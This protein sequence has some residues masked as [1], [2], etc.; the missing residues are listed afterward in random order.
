MSTVVDWHPILKPQAVSFNLRGQ[1]IIGGVSLTG[2]TQVALLDSGYWIAQYSG[3]VVSTPAKVRAYRAL[4][5]SLRGGAFQVRL[6]AV[7]CSQA[8]WPDGDADN[9]QVPYD[10]DAL[11]DDDTGFYQPVIAVVLDV[12]GVSGDSIVTVDVQNA[13]DI[14][15][16]M[17]FSLDSGNRMH[18]I[19]MVLSTVGSIQ[20]WAISPRLRSA[21]SVGEELDF[22]DPRCLMRLSDEGAA[23]L[24]LTTGKFG[25]P[26]MQFVEVLA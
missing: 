6:P 2:R 8:P 21:Y 23:D 14:R 15:P 18:V 25:T 5:A 12:A 22:D 17:L 10:D 13:G 1:T 11:H 26:D 20:Q 9:E 3:I 7:D 4:A 16:G 19:R 24:M